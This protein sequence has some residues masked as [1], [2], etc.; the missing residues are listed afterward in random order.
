MAD[1]VQNSYAESKLHS[2]VVFQRGKPLLDYELNELQ[3]IQ[4]VFLARV[5]QDGNVYPQGQQVS[6]SSNDGYKIVGT[7]AANSV[8]VKAGRLYC[9]GIPVLKTTDSAFSTLTTNGAGNPRYDVIYLEVTEV[10]IADPAAIPQLGETTRRRQIQATV[11]VVEGVAAASP[12]EPALPADSASE[13]W[14]GG[15][16]RFKLA[17]ILRPAG[18]SVI[19]AGNVTDLRIAPMPFR[20]GLVEDRVSDL[21]LRPVFNVRAAAFGAVGDGVTVDTTA[22]QACIDA[23]F[24]VSG[25]VEFPPGTY[26]TGLLTLPENV[27]LRGTA[28]ATFI[29]WNHA[30]ANQLVATATHTGIPC[31]ITDLQFVGNIVTTGSSV[32]NNS[33][34]RLQ[35]IRCSWNGSVDNLQGKIFSVNSSLSSID[36]VDCDLRIAGSLKGIH[37]TNGRVRMFRGS[38]TLVEATYNDAMAYAD[39]N[40]EI[41]LNGVRLDVTAHT[42]NTVQGLYAASTTAKCSMRDCFLDATG[43]GGTVIGFLWVAGA[44]VVSLDN[45]RKGN[46][47]PHGSGAPSTDSVVEL[48]YR[49]PVTTTSGGNS[50]TCPDWVRTFAVKWTAGATAPTI[51]MPNIMSPGQRFTLINYNTS[52]GSFAG[53]TLAGSVAPTGYSGIANTAVKILEF[54][55]VDWDVNGSSE[56]LCIGERG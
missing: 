44:T 18:T 34:G 37:V 17:R 14:E 39:S 13:I 3:D 50:I 40:G 42:T 22:I 27:S 53:V 10:E 43:A 12:V 19:S 45:I 6:V 2:A 4:R 8:T 33:G 32:V 29:A 51:T 16:H 7:G 26:L 49:L 56:W 25:I 15:V 5:F 31:T 21:E 52:G 9:D 30:T 47:T 1:V 24:V 11:K 54:E 55:A 38:I 28:D 46:V 41:E 23:A 48:P 36:L 20:I 35:F